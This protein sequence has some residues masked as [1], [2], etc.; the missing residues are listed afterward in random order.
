MKDVFGFAEHQDNC[1]YE[2][3]SKLTLQRISD[4][5]ALSHPAGDKD[6]ANF[7]LAGRVIIDDISLY[8]PHYSP[9]VSDR[10]LMLRHIVSRAATKFSHIKRSF[11][12]KDVTTENN[13][14]L[15]LV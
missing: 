6:A 5:H 13:G 14:I 8:V 11:Y 15:S 7:A 2:W 10:N 1:T 12:M 9:N 4:N 3:G